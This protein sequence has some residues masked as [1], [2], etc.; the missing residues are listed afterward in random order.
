[1][2]ERNH[3]NQSL[4]D[5]KE[6]IAGLNAEGRKELAAAAVEAV[7]DEAKR[8]LV[9]AAVQAVPGEA[10]RDVLAAAVHAAP[11]EAKSG[12]VAAAVQDAGA[13]TKRKVADAALRTLPAADQEELAQRFLPDQPITN[14]IWMTIVRTFAVVLL[15]A[16]LALVGAVFVSMFREVDA[17]LVQILLTAFTTVAGMLAGFISGRTSV[18]RGSA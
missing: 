18:G 3:A 5:M 17:A 9:A 4:D 15:C 6:S 1:M 8:E 11:D 7:P 14:E 13:A 2:A 12:L 16:T 10:V